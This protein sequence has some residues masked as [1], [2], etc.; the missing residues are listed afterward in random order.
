[1]PYSVFDS[2]KDLDEARTQSMRSFSLSPPVRESLWTVNIRDLMQATAESPSS[3]RLVRLTEDRD[4]SSRLEKLQKLARKSQET[5]KHSWNTRKQLG[6][7][8]DPARKGDHAARLLEKDA[9]FKTELLHTEHRSGKGLG[10]KIRVN[11]QAVVDGVKH[12]IAGFKGKAARSTASQLSKLERPYLSKD[13]DMQYIEAYDNFV[14]QSSEASSCAND[15]AEV[16]VGSSDDQHKRRLE[17]LETQRE[18]FRAAYTTTR[19]VQRVSRVNPRRLSKF[20]NVGGVRM[21]TGN[22]ERFK[23]G[24]MEWIGN[25]GSPKSIVDSVSANYASPFCIWHKT[26]LGST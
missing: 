19:F 18:G 12:P 2:R 5:T 3:A 25:V 17:L 9:A 7:P 21:E 4:S 14:Q 8:Q 13:M 23:Y 24:W 11:A 22:Q 1:M 20:P 15:A 16:A 6:K 26:S 10:A